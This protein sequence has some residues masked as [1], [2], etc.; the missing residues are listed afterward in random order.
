VVD[1][2][3][4]S[5]RGSFGYN[6]YVSTGAADPGDASRFIVAPGT[7]GG[8]GVGPPTIGG[9]KFT[10]Q[11][12][13]PTTGAI[14]VADSGTGNTNDYEGI[15]SVL[16]GH[17]ATDAAVYPTSPLYA[18][19]YVNGG[20]GS[21]LST[22]VLFNA[23]AWL[24]DKSGT[25]VNTGSPGFRADPSEL[26]AAFY[27]IINLTNDLLSKANAG[28]NFTFFIDQ[29]EIGSI[30]AGAAVSQFQNPGT[31]SLIR[32][33]V[34]PFLQQGN[35]HL[36]SYTMPATY[37]NISNVWENIM[38]QDYLSVSWPVIDPTFRYSIFLYGA[39]VAY[40]P[41]YNGLLAG[42]QKSAVTPFS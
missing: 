34:H 28:T 23:L 2:T 41:Q 7:V 11:G 17:A 29:D 31:R 21:V 12:A 26:V 20:L 14:P 6:L 39:L 27:D 15:Q 33:M 42:L 5:V 25:G 4:N 35:A 32:I 3:V 19:G 9:V 40:A 18:G 8:I 13:L 24:F 38:V 30:R 1:V 16:S 37:T 22:A 36:L 10:L